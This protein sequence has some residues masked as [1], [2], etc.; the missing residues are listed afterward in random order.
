MIE[1]E[2][3]VYFIESAMTGARYDVSTGE[4]MN[5]I[6]TLFAKEEQ[7]LA[8]ARTLPHWVNWRIE[9]T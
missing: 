1:N 4:F 6:G 3:R 7:A 5:D 2:P 8:V 9:H